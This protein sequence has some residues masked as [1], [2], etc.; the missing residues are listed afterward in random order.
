MSFLAPAGPAE[1]LASLW[2]YH[3]GWLIHGRLIYPAPSLA[4]GARHLFPVAAAIAS[5]STLNSGRVKPETIIS[6]DAGGGS[7]A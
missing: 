3:H 2:W 1:R 6:V 5:T 7:A 4:K